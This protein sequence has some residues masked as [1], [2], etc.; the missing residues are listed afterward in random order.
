M[1]DDLKPPPQIKVQPGPLFPLLANFCRQ[2]AILIGGSVT[3]LSLLGRGD[4]NAIISYLSGDEILPVLAAASVVI[5]SLSSFWKTIHNEAVKRRLAAEVG[6]DLAAIQRHGLGRWL[7]AILTGA[8]LS[9]CATVAAESP[10]QKLFAARGYWNIAKAAGVDYAESPTARGDVVL[11]IVRIRDT[12][13]P[14]VDYVDAY[15]ACRLE[16]KTSVVVFG[17]LEPLPCATFNFSNA[18]IGS[19]ALA[20]RT[21]AMQILTKTGR[22]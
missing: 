19:A 3:L 22:P 17:T 6:D 1:N 12:V 13:Q 2:L 14:N 16:G 15:V 20:L 9:G 8:A 5:A 21:A 11:A 4:V 10:A 18:S 7:I